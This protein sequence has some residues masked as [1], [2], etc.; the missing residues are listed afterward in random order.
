MPACSIVAHSTALFHVVQMV[1]ALL[2]HH[3]VVHA[4]EVGQVLIRILSLLRPHRIRLHLNNLALSGAKLVVL[5]L[6]RTVG[7]SRL[8]LLAL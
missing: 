3:F 1:T 6:S 2:E 4:L 5:N 7:G 8:V